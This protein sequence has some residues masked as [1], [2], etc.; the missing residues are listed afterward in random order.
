MEELRPED[1]EELV[2]ELEQDGEKGEV[3]AGLQP[4]EA[5][6]SYRGAQRLDAG[7]DAARENLEASR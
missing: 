6:Q 2:Q 3:V 7:F 5:V 4:E 1:L